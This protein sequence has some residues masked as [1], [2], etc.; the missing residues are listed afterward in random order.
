MTW[1]TTTCIRDGE[2]LT[3][4]ET[5]EG[6]RIDCFREDDAAEIVRAV[7]AFHVLTVLSPADRQDLADRLVHADI[8]AIWSFA[9]T[10]I[11]V[12]EGI[13]VRHEHLSV[14]LAEISY[15]LKQGK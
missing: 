12:P 1:K 6:R 13:M 11:T 8:R 7:N 9:P 5:D 14:G 4:V 2:R 3:Q 10:R 15:F